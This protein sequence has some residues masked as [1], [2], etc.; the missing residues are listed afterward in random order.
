MF[1][2]A[3]SAA[4]QALRG[5]RALSTTPRAAAAAQRVVLVDG[6]RIP[7][8][9]S[10]TVY[11]VVWSPHCC[12]VRRFCCRTTLTLSWLL[13]TPTTAH[14]THSYTHKQHKYS[15]KDLIAQD[16]QRMAIKGLV[17]RNALEPTDPDCVVTGNVIQEGAKGY[18]LCS[19]SHHLD[20][21]TAGVVS[22]LLLLPCVPF[23]TCAVRTSNIA[24]EAALAAGISNK[25]PAH[26]VT[27]ACISSNVAVSSAAGM[28]HAGA[29][30]NHE[31]AAAPATLL[32]NHIAFLLL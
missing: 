29:V 18:P 15:Y 6:C 9:M 12:V 14:C 21:P 4:V 3:R 31:P 20:Q 22:L 2:T 19:P 8:H 26:T 1:S 23:H 5:V 25:V 11:V 13:C 17:S 16:L 32:T 27:L 24:R 10:G 7:F 30:E 28:I